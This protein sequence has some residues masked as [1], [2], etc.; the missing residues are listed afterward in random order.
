MNNVTSAT[1]RPLS[2]SNMLLIAGCLLEYSRCPP[3][4]AFKNGDA[5]DA[6]FKLG[7]KKYRMK[8]KSKAT[9]SE[10]GHHHSRCRTRRD[11]QLSQLYYVT[12]FE[13]LFFDEPHGDH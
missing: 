8:R 11:G 13:V 9:A 1:A 3:V 10:I 4:A 6:L 12:E 2:S 7:R 5:Q